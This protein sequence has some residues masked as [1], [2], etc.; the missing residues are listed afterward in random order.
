MSRLKVSD[1]PVFHEAEVVCPIEHDVV[2]KRDGVDADDFNNAAGVFKIFASLVMRDSPKRRQRTWRKRLNKNALE[3]A[4]HK[5]SAGATTP[6][7]SQR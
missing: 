6:I 7:L 5:Y 2:E 3:S 1:H 4:E